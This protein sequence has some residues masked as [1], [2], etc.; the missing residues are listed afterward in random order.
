LGRAYSGGLV[1]N[2]TRQDLIVE[3]VGTSDADRLE[4]RAQTS[5]RFSALGGE[6]LGTGVAIYAVDGELL[7]TLDQRICDGG[8]LT[9]EQEDLGPPENA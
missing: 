7:T 5:G 2:D 9:I 4:I 8:L 1:A 6:C 3:V